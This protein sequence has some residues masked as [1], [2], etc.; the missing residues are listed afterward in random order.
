M[1]FTSAQNLSHI[2]TKFHRIIWLTVR[3]SIWY[4]IPDLYTEVYVPKKKL[5]IKSFIG[6]L[7]NQTDWMVLIYLKFLKWYLILM[8]VKRY[9]GYLRPN[10]MDKVYQCYMEGPFLLQS[11]IML[12]EIAT[13]VFLLFPLHKIVMDHNPVYKN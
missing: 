5:N 13:L 9:P 6:I 2:C 12:W 1:Y 4:K 7:L 11:S 10:Q 8:P 3:I